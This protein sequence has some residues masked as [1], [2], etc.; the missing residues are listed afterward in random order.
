MALQD[1]QTVV[2]NRKFLISKSIP[3]HKQAPLLYFVL[4]EATKSEVDELFLMLC[5]IGGAPTK[6]V[7]SL[8]RT[9][10]GV[11]LMTVHRTVKLAAK[12]MRDHTPSAIAARQNLVAFHAAL[13]KK[14]EEDKERIQRI[15]KDAGLAKEYEK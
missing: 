8:L 14:V 2:E 11:Q 4:S 6:R 9:K 7:R 5:Q 3:P 10:R 15:L 12:K 1:Y 13:Q